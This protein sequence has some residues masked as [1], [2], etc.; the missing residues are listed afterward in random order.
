L[1]TAHC[2]L[3]EARSEF[4]GSG[5]VDQAVIRF[6]DITRQGTIFTNATAYIQAA[7]L[8]IVESSI[9]IKVWGF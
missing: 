9:F 7:L 3:T 2:D 6:L 4:G 1:L 8:K 5:G